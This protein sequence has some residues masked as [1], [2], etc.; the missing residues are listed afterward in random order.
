MSP[1]DANE[2]TLTPHGSLGDSNH[3]MN[4][5]IPK[6]AYFYLINISGLGSQRYLRNGQN[7]VYTTV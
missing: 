1:N 7:F 3:V 5:E 2:G 6:K 4:T